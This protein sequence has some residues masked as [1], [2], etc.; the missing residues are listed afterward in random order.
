MYLR[1]WPPWISKDSGEP[2]VPLLVRKQALSA[3]G[4]QECSASPFWGPPSPDNRLCQQKSYFTRGFLFSSP[5]Q[6]KF[7]RQ[8]QLK[9]RTWQK[10]TPATFIDRRGYFLCCHF[11]WR[12]LQKKGGALRPLPFHSFY[13]CVC[14]KRIYSDYRFTLTRFSEFIIRLT[15]AA[16]SLRLMLVM[17]AKVPA[18]SLP[19]RMPAR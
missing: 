9:V 15:M 6:N 14:I 2:C 11:H 1:P 12:G 18:A 4:K 19:L 7:S 17:G 13:S 16:T 5:A 8:K 3:P 10:I